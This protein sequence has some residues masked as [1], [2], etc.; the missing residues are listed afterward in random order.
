MALDGN[1]KLPLAGEV[2]K[3]TALVGG[4][5]V[6][7]ILVVS[8]LRHSKAQA[9]ATPAST[10]TTVSD[11]TG[12]DAGIDPATGVPYADETTSAL[13]TY[14][15]GIDPSTGIPYAEE[16]GYGGGVGAGGGGGTTST[17][18]I[19]TNDQ[20]LEEAEGQFPGHTASQAFTRILGGVAVT[21]NQK[22]LFM[23]AVGVFG[24]PPQGYPQPIKLLDTKGHPG[25]TK[26]TITA[27]GH[28]TLNGIAKQYAI[29]EATLVGYNPGLKRYEGTGK[30]IPAGTRVVV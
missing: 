17:S 27:N 24:N 16:L 9:A 28:L 1:I 23:E 5:V 4:G 10:D 12:T 14:D 19:S 2:S 21:A 29:S 25:P 26:H 7:A 11:Q 30:D 13:G 20:W 18:G 15:T 8:Y 3:K 6:V 22:D